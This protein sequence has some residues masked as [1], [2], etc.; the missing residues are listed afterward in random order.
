MCL[1]FFC[2]FCQSSNFYITDLTLA[3][4]KLYQTFVAQAAQL[5]SVHENVKVGSLLLLDFSFKKYKMFKKKSVGHFKKIELTS[6][7][8]VLMLLVFRFS[9]GIRSWSTSTSLTVGLSSKIPRT[10]LSPNV[11]Q[12]ESGRARPKLQRGPHHSPAFPMLQ[13][14]PWQPRWPSNSSQLQVWLPT[15]FRKFCLFIPLQ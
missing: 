12:T 7:V 13:P 9:A 5:Q 2:F 8:C 15:S 1:V 6:V 4:Q 3:M 14:L 11:H 10:S